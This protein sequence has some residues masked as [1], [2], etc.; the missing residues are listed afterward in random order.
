LAGQRARYTANQLF[1]FHVGL[2]DNPL[3]QQYM[4]AAA[5]NLN[6]R[7]ARELSDYFSKLPPKAAND[8][9]VELVAAG[10]A[11]YQNGIPEA[12][13]VSCVA[14][15]GPRA[16]GVGGIP[17]LGGLSYAYLRRRLGQWGEGYHRAAEPPMP[18][19]ASKLP[20]NQIEALASYL[21]FVK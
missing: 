12:N 4:W 2:R 9:E 13:I 19:I 10:R 3:S 1:H 18:R 5:A 17:R 11:I 15:H 6:S 7:S 8:G 20:P 14:C 21:S 16:E